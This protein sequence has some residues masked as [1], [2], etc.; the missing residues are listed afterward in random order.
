LK[1]GIVAL[2]SGRHRNHRLVE[3]SAQTYSW[4]A[5]CKETV[6]STNIPLCLKIDINYFAIAVGCS[7]KI[8][9]LVVDFYKN[10]SDVACVA[11]ASVKSL[12]PA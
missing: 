5:D 3:H 4:L 2:K 1:Y 6:S 8:M 11:E 7:P 9:L 12:Q 10:F